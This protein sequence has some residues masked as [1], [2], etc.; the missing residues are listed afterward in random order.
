MKAIRQV[1]TLTRRELY[2]YFCSPIAYV[3]IVIFLITI[4]IFTFGDGLGSFYSRGVADLEIPFFT[5]HPWLFM[6][7]VPAIGMR[8][9]AE[10]RHKGTLELLSTMPLRL[11]Q[12]VLSKFLAGAAVLAAALLLTFPIV[13]SVNYLGDPDNGKIGCGFIGSFLMGEAFLSLSSLTS[14]ITRNQVISFVL[15]LVCCLFLIL[16]GF[17]AVTNVL[18]QWNLPQPLLD[19]VTNLS[20]YTHYAALQRGVIDTRDISYFVVVILFGLLA[21]TVAV[22]ER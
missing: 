15:A 6:V 21:T 4:G 9:W 12:A 8:L 3:F 7:L 2:S 16:C 5:W 22:K 20:V 19:F 17:P 13:I 11:W 10:E 18:L 1:W 14:A